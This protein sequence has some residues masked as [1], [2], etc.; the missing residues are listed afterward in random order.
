[1]ETILGLILQM[2][3]LICQILVCVLSLH[4]RGAR[5]EPP[6]QDTPVEEQ[7]KE[8]TE[9]ERRMQEYMKKMQ[10]GVNNILNYDGTAQEGKQ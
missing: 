2:L 7:N 6:K 9:E 5:T 10:E 4:L 3:I 1:M 8:I